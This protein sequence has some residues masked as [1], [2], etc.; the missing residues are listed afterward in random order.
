MIALWGAMFAW[1]AI[2]LGW[3]AFN[4]SLYAGLVTATP[5]LAKMAPLNAALL[6]FVAGA[7]IIALGGYLIGVIVYG[8]SRRKKLG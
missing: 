4:G 6:A 1:A 3:V 7:A 2:T 5:Q 8:L